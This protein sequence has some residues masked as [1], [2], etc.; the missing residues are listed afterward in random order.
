MNDVITRQDLL[1]NGPAALEKA[2]I[3]GRASAITVH[4]SGGLRFASAAEVMDFA[5]MM[6]IAGTH[7]PQYL[8]ANVGGCLAIILQ[9]LH[10]EMDPFQVANKSY[11][12]NNRIGYESQLLHAVVE[13]RAPLQH[14][15]ACNYEGEGPER[16]CIVTGHFVTGDTRE[17]RS[18]KFKD[19]RPKNSPLWVNDP[20]QQQWYFASRAWARKWTP[21]VLMDIYTREELRDDPSLGR[22]EADS[23]PVGLHARLVG[24][25]RGQDGHNESQLATELASVLTEDDGQMDL[26]ER[27]DLAVDKPKEQTATEP[28]PKKGKAKQAAEK[29]PRNI[30]E[31]VKFALTWIKKADDPD[32]LFDRWKTERGLRN[33]LGVTLEDREPLDAAIAKRRAELS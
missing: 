3:M 33:K 23:A 15:L 25:S 17:Y 32:E 24:S 20:D 13:A 19:I 26:A 16:V 6:S 18:P 31:Y 5:K 28:K 30:D 7:L 27:P 12:V 2:G 4:R 9:A 21:D 8:R 14:R 22:E 11:E 1:N 29:T 10:W